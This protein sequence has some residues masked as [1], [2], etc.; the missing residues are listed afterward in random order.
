MNLL[1]KKEYIA[2]NLVIHQVI[3]YEGANEPPHSEFVTF[4]HNNQ[5]FQIG[6]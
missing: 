5:Y 2:N 6:F 4:K 3:E 1:M